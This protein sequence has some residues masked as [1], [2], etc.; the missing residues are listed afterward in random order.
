MYALRI[1]HKRIFDEPPDIIV[2]SE[3]CWN[4][5]LETALEEEHGALERCQVEIVARQS[6]VSWLELVQADDLGDRYH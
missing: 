2:Q 6:R 4:S 1:L 3:E 5:K